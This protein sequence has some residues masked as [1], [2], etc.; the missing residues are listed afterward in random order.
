M[1]QAIA[2]GKGGGG[3]TPGASNA[4][5]GVVTVASGAGSKAITF[6]VAFGAAPAVD[7]VLL[8]PDNTNSGIDCWPDESTRTA[9]GVTFLFADTTPNAN[10]K[11]S[12]IAVGN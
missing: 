11:L 10:Y 8:L 2:I 3:G 7:G 1:H 12:W 6:N 4:D 9:L 5:G